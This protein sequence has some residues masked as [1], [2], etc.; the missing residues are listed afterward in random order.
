MPPP[1]IPKMNRITNMRDSRLNHMP[2]RHVSDN[3]ID[4]AWGDSVFPCKNSGV[5]LS[6]DVFTSNCFYVLWR[7]RGGPYFFSIS[8][9]SLT[10]HVSYV[11][12]LCSYAEM[13]RVATWRIVASVQNF[14]AVWNVPKYDSP[15][16]SVSAVCFCLEINQPV[17]LRVFVS[18]KI[19]TRRCAASNNSFP[20][21]CLERWGQFWDRAWFHNQKPNPAAE[22]TS[23]HEWPQL[24]KGWKNLIASCFSAT[25]RPRRLNHC[26]LSEST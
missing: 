5:I 6:G 24:P 16:N 17:S 14:E 9:T 13:K 3:E 20:K 4:S 10:F 8:P 15:R 21:L 19:P 1:T 11:V 18:G 22:V 26:C 23:A 25:L 7:E 2:P 12:G